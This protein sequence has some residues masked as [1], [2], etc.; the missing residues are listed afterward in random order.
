MS[1]KTKSNNRISNAISFLMS[2]STALVF[3]FLP[4]YFYHVGVTLVNIGIIV[5]ISVVTT[6][7]VK[8]IAGSF[9]DYYDRRKVMLIGGLIMA[10]TNLS[11]AFFV[12]EAFLITR[13]IIYG[14]GTAIFYPAYISYV[15]DISE[16]KKLSTY[17]AIRSAFR[18]LG[19]V[20]AP[21]VGGLIIYLFGFKELFYTAF[22]VGLSTLGLLFMLTDTKHTNKLP[23][24][25]RVVKNYKSILITKGFTLLSFIRL[26]RSSAQLVW[27]TFILIY[28]RSAVGYDF[29]QA[30]LVIMGSSIVL[31]PFQLPLGKFSDKFHS[32]WLIIPGFLM[33]GIFMKLFFTVNHILAYTLMAGGVA[34]GFLAIDRPIYVRLAEMTPTNKHGQAVAIFESIT[35]GLAAIA[36]FY[37]GEFAEIFS[38]KEVISYVSSFVLGVG[39]VLIAFHRKI[40]WKYGNHLRRYHLIRLYTPIDQIIDSFPELSRGFKRTRL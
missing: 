32:K 39:A 24:M 27:A 23:N 7:V 4:L 17:G 28:L 25:D 15:W 19:R 26:I 10:F 40:T 1:I 8:L 12:S 2:F 31:L 34:I 18:H 6:N 20:V 33:I 36:L 11:L 29:W 30:G 22:I 21:L 37:A 5:A 14:I 35:W 16:L 13:G 9:I 38:I 3:V